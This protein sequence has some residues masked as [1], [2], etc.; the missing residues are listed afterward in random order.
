MV[1]ITHNL[2]D[3]LLS[4]IP[5][6]IV[7]ATE[8][9]PVVLHIAVLVTSAGKVEAHPGFNLILVALELGAVLLFDLC[10][11]TLLLVIGCE[12]VVQDSVP[13]KPD[14]ILLCRLEEGFELRSCSP[15]CCL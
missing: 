6:I 11:E 4:L 8:M 12:L 1:L 3:G 14:L 7:H 15:F 9:I 13:I 10:G 5:R 2:I